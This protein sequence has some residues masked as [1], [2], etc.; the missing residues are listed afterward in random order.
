MINYRSPSRGGIPQEGGSLDGL[1][2]S[3][4]LKRIFR[5][6]RAMERHSVAPN[7]A[8][9]SLPL[10]CHPPPPPC[11]APPFSCVTPKGFPLCVDCRL[12]GD[13]ELDTANL[14]LSGYG[15]NEMRY[16]PEK[17]TYLVPLIDGPETSRGDARPAGTNRSTLFFFEGFLQSEVLSLV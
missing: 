12:R 7:V 5:V 6:P 10:R 2:V 11:I 13:C 17:K 15:V 8:A 3:S 4:F 14:F 1:K 9:T 16:V